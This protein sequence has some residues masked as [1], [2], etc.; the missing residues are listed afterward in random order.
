MHKE[1][2]YTVNADIARM[3]KEIRDCEWHMAEVWS[4]LMSALEEKDNENI[5]LQLC[6]K[7][8][9]EEQSRDKYVSALITLYEKE[10][11]NM[12]VQDQ[13]DCLTEKQKQTICFEIKKLEECANKGYRTEKFSTETEVPGDMFAK[14]LQEIQQ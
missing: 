1:F 4:A 2:E 5:A 10:I 8:K 12:Q 11:P 3:Q 7:Y 13:K 14:F 9:T 6:I